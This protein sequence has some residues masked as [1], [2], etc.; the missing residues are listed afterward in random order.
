MKGEHLLQDVAQDRH[1]MQI[2]RRARGL[3]DGQ[4]EVVVVFGLE[5]GW[6][7][8][9][10]HGDEGAVDL[11][12]L[13]RRR[14]L[15]GAPCRPDLQVRAYLRQVVQV[16]AVGADKL[17]QGGV[18]LVGRGR[19]PGAAAL[20]GGDEALGFQLLQGGADRNPADPH[21]VGQLALARQAFARGQFAAGDQPQQFI[22]D[23]VGDALAGNFLESR[24]HALA[25]RRL[26]RSL[27][28]KRIAGRT[29]RS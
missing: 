18:E 6:A 20:D 9:R 4:V 29:S 14:P 22:G 27:L 16:V 24:I 26:C 28:P 25:P 21:H 2:D 5:A 8:L 7:P 11:G 10:R 13:L 12:A 19:D 1:E 17:R 23:A 3:G 15:G